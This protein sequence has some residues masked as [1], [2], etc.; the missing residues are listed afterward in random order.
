MKNK[1]EEL[2]QKR[3]RR[4]K[5]KVAGTSERPRL[6]VHKSHQNMCTQLIDDISGKTLV[7]A[8]TLEKDFLKKSKSGGNIKAA[9]I[10]GEYLA[11]KAKE[12]GIK[13]VV[14]D[15]G[16]FKYHGRIKALAES[17]RKAGLEF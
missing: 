12:K 16:G 9:T 5:R 17:A 15:R 13:K 11:G 8:S 14:F 4:I 1:P 3:H 2:R 6:S 7:A 10:L